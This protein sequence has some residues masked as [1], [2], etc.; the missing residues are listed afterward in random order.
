M[1]YRGQLGAMRFADVHGSNHIG[2]FRARSDVKPL[3]RLTQCDRG[4]ERAEGLTH[5]HHRN[6]A[7][8]ESAGTEFHSP[9]VPCEDA[10]IGDQARGFG[11][12]AGKTA[13]THSLDSI[14]KL[15]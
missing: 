10:A 4:R 3:M 13:V 8:P 14:R 15:T 7:V 12:R 5:F 1:C 11:A 2:K 6:A 9:S